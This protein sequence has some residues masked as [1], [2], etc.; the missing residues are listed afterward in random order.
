MYHQFLFSEADPKATQDELLKEL[1]QSISTQ[2]NN[3]FNNNID[4]S[5]CNEIY[6][7]YKTA[8]KADTFCKL[9]IN[10][11]DQL[12]KTQKTKLILKHSIKLPNDIEGLN[13]LLVLLKNV[14][15]VSKLTVIKPDD[16][17]AK[18]LADALNDNTT[19][20]EIILSHH[21]YS[22][23]ND[24]ITHDG[25]ERLAKAL[26]VNTTLKTLNLSNNNVGDEGAKHLA[27]ALEANTT[28]KT[29]NLSN[30]NIGFKGTINGANAIAT[31]LTF[32][33]TLEI[34]D[35]SNNK[36]SGAAANRIFKALGSD[37]YLDLSAP[38]GNKTTIPGVKTV[39][40]IHKKAALTDILL[41]NNKINSVQS[42]SSLNDNKTLKYLNLAYNSLDDDKIKV[43]AKMLKSNNTL[44]EI[45]LTGNK[46]TQKGIDI[47]QKALNE[48]ALKDNCKI[49]ISDPTDSKTIK[50][51]TGGQ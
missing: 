24:G 4:L 26:E 16:N 23:P 19:L 40:T 14:S 25:A 41:Q 12:S 17:T 2:L 30:N 46:V 48:K 8:E 18:H 20:K 10:Q 6:N 11:I 29:L 43:I 21:V 35:L 7:K 39:E 33:I 47:F 13:E 3:T 9:V 5:I 32:N 15:K 45:D 22:N 28:L 44:K 50:T 1:N 38:G 42:I 31:M 27:K 51:L 37:N 36:I 49:F 34:I